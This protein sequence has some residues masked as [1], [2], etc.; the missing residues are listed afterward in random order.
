MVKLRLKELIR[1][2]QV[3]R[4]YSDSQLAALLAGEGIRISRRTVAKY[5]EELQILPSLERKRWS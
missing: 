1:T 3:S 5:R 4:P 2:E